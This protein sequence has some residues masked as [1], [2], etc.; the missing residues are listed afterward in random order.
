MVYFIAELVYKK[1]QGL[2]LGAEPPRPSPCEI[3][4]SPPGQYPLAEDQLNFA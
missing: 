1:G 3:L 2:H 4:F